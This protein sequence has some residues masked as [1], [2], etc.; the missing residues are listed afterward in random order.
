MLGACAYAGAAL[1][2]LELSVLFLVI[3]VELIQSIE[4]IGTVIAL[5]DTGNLHIHGFIYSINVFPGYVNFLLLT[6][7]INEI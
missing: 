3:C 2:A 7:A 1:D 5:E 4:H 6:Y